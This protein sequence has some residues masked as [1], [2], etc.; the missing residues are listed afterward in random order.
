MSLDA[1]KEVA[2]L[3]KGDSGI[4]VPHPLGHRQDIGTHVDQEGGV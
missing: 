2:V 4:R 1:L 3:T